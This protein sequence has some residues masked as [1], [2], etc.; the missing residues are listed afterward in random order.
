MQYN[1]LRILL[2][3]PAS[4]PKA[5]LV[6]DCGTLKMKYRIMAIKLTFLHY[7]IAQDEESLAHQIVMEQKS[8]N[9]PGLV[10]EC[11]QFINELKILDPFQYTLSKQ[12]WK[13]IV[14]IAIVTANTNELKEEIIEN[15]RS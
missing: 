3:T 7:I 8:E 11:S 1:F 13:R 14:K 12:E 6:W 5:A 4:T 15:I 9:F 2:A 10:Q